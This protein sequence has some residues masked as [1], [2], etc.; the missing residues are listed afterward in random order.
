MHTPT[1]PEHTLKKYKILEY[2]KFFPKK[3][4]SEFHGFN[5]SRFV[6]IRHD[7]KVENHSEQFI[8]VFSSGGQNWYKQLMEMSTG[9]E[10]LKVEFPHFLGYRAWGFFGFS[11]DCLSRLLTR[12]KID[13]NFIGW[14]KFCMKLKEFWAVE[15]KLKCLEPCR[16]VLDRFLTRFFYA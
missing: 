4:R 9:K 3:L 13:G 16:E 10:K 12:T 11:S 14:R 15:T 1:R 7:G 8:S 5:N 6:K 2:D